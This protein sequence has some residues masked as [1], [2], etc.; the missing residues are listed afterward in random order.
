MAAKAT[1]PITSTV[2]GINEVL[3]ADIRRLLTVSMMAWQLSRESKYG[4]SG[5]TMI[6]SSMSQQEKGFD[7]MRRTVL[8]I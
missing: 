4:L 1:S 3:H 6:S 5:E 7:S 8:G 2:S